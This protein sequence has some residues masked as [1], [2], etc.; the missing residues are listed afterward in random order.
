MN[1]GRNNLTHDDCTYVIDALLVRMFFV[2]LKDEKVGGAS[3]R[4]AN[5]ERGR[6]MAK[7]R[8]RSGHQTLPPLLPPLASCNLKGRVSPPPLPAH[9]GRVCESD[10]SRTQR[11]QGTISGFFSSRGRCFWNRFVKD[12]GFDHDP[13]KMRLESANTGDA[14]RSFTYFPI[15]YSILLYT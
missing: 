1:V 6:K 9:R 14:I 11:V 3:F 7:S 5:W 2:L 13:G 15:S 4:R 12:S 10:I 8:R